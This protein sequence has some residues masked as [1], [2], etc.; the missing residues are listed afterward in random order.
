MQYCSSFL[1]QTS[2]STEPPLIEGESPKVAGV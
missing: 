2:T 1:P